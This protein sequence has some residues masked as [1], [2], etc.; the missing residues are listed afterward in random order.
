MDARQGGS[1]GRTARSRRFAVRLPGGA[2]SHASLRYLLWPLWLIWL[3]YLAYPL[4]T[5]AGTHPPAARLA[6]SAGAVVLFAA[7]YAWAA[8]H[9]TECLGAQGYHWRARYALPPAA[10]ALVSLVLSLA[11][12]RDWLLL[13]DYAAAVAGVFL[14]LLA[15]TGA[16]AGLFAVASATSLSLQGGWTSVFQAPYDVVLSGLSTVGV[17]WLLDMNRALRDARQEIARL[18][19]S[20]ERLR[21]AR[22]LHDLLGHSLSLIAIKSELAGR[23]VLSSPER[24]ATEIGDVESVARAA[25]QEVRAAVA[26]YRAATLAD[27]LDSA[28]EILDAAGVALTCDWA[29]G[30]LPLDVE[31]VLAWIVREGMTNVIKHSRARHCLVRLVLDADSACISVENDGPAAADPPASGGTG[32]IGLSERVDEAGGRFTAAALPTGGFRIAAAVPLHRSTG[33]QPVPAASGERGRTEIGT[34]QDV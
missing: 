17:V 28:R 26:G 15:G 30:P 12:G 5:L 3:P 25:L 1:G 33:R 19:V 16:T 7:L 34:V 27:E 9:L 4:T 8:W 2:G 13:F 24:A 21:F 10:M 18:A 6:I 23:L 11:D 20:E 32:L 22:D 29:C 14:P 31:R